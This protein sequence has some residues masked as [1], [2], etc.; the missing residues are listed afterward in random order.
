MSDEKCLKIGWAHR[1]VS[2]DGPIGI[3]G[4]FYLRIS[5]GIIDPVTL[6]VLVVDDGAD[7]VIFVSADMVVIRSYLLDQIRE[8]TAK[9]NPAIPVEK[10]LMN[11]THA[12]TGPSHYASRNLFDDK[13]SGSSTAYS[14]DYP[15]DIDMISG[16]EY[17]DFLSAKAAEAIAEAW[18][19]RAPGGIAWGYGYATVG[20]S[21]RVVYFDDV[22][23]RPDNVAR[24]GMMVNGHGVMY[25]NTNDDNFS[26]YEAGTESFVNLLYTFDPNGELTGAIVN[27]PCP[28]QNSE[29]EW[30]L[31]ADF[32]HDTRTAI[33]KKFGNIFILPQCA[34]AGDLAPRILHYK[35]AQERRFRL[36]YGTD[37]EKTYREADARRDIAE[38]ITAAFEE[39]LGWAKKDIRTALPIKHIVET[40][41]LSKRLITR[42][43][44]EAERAQ[45]E[46]LMKEPFKTDGTKVDRLIHNSI[47]A[48]R[49][50]RCCQIISRYETQEAE[51]KLPM[52]LHVLKIGDI[53][54]ASNRFELYMDYMHRM[55]ARSPFEQTFIVQ[56]AG[57]PGFDGGSYLATER[58][59]A[60]RG[61]SAS[62]YCNQVSSKGGQE[63]VEE[64]VKILKEIY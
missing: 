59:E 2:V 38:R 26:H 46:E 24:P 37:P 1:D 49:R 47:L 4:Q 10:I 63:L 60:N 7:S 58:G 14:G 6:T 18:D 56:L 57:T 3:P 43:E 5:E 45:L 30:K 29:S 21:R 40:V 62:L 16:D 13:I 48:S 42:E 20:H 50:N 39:V 17:R 25:G 9:L 34:A 54:F 33:R 23:Q 51:P 8:K 36:K 31:S 32:W 12:H 52:E 11:V 44:M 28:S 27:V 53:A 64:T 19:K 35:K 15:C 55:Q 61:Y 41:E 22:S